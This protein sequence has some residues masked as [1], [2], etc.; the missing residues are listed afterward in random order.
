[1]VTSQKPAGKVCMCVTQG[2]TYVNLIFL[3]ALLEI[4]C[5]STIADICQHDHVVDTTATRKIKSL[6][7]E[8]DNKKRGQRQRRSSDLPQNASLLPPNAPSRLSYVLL[9]STIV[10]SSASL[11][12]KAV[13]SFL[14]AGTRVQA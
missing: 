12:L 3:I 10:C 11:R 7:A 14:P 5:N 1:M 6:D 8:N 4:G 2:S 13:Q 9:V